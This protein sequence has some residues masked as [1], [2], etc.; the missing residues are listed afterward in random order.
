MRCHNFSGIFFSL[1]MGILLACFSADG[2]V[3]LVENGQER[4]VVITATPPSKIAAYAATELIAHVEKATGVR[5]QVIGEDEL[6]DESLC[7]IFIGVTKEAKSLGYAPDSLTPDTFILRTNGPRLY[8]FGREEP[9]AD[10]LRANVPSGTLF[11]VYELLERYVGVRW[12]WPGDLGTV[13]PRH[14]TLAI[15]GGLNE[16]QTPRL[17][18]RQ[19]RWHHVNHA[20]ADY[21]PEIERI[22]FSKEGLIAYRND[23]EI[24]LKRNRIGATEPKPKTGHYFCGWWPKYGKEHPEWFMLNEEGVRGPGSK[25][26]VERWRLQHVG[27]CV[28]NPELQQFLVE[29]AWDGSEDLD[30]SETDYRAFCH[31]EHCRSWD[32]E[33]PEGYYPD[34]HRMGWD[35]AL[36]GLSEYDDFIPMNVSD[37]YARFWKL[38]HEKAKERNPNVSVNTYLYWNYF[39]APLQEINLDGVYGEFVP[40]TRANKWMPMPEEAYEWNKEQWLGWQKTGMRMA[41]R[42]NYFHGGYVMPQISTRQA[43][44]FIRFAYKHGM[45]GVDFDS[46][47]GHWAIKAPMFYIHFRLF[48]NPELEVNQL[49]QE[50]FDAFGPSAPL[51]E[52]YTEY[53]EHHAGEACVPLDPWP[54][55]GLWSPVRAHIHYPAESFIPAAALL[56]EAHELA[57]QSNQMEYANRIAFL[58]HGLEHARL[59]G[60]LMAKLVHGRAPVFDPQRFAEAQQALKDLI[61][62]RRAFEHE[63]IADYLYAAIRENEYCEIDVLLR[64]AES[65]LLPNLNDRWGTWRFRKDTDNRG[66]D[67]KWYLTTPQE[68]EWA[69]V[70]TPGTWED[71]YQGY[72]WYHNTVNLPKDWKD[73]PLTLLFEGVSEEAW[74]YVNGQFVGEHTVSAKKLP[75]AILRTWPFE[76]SVPEKLLEPGAENSVVVRV[77]ASHHP[78]GF[79]GPVYGFVRDRAKTKTA[80]KPWG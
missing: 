32:V 2:T 10:P 72:A 48:W 6:A 58:Q 38:M 45:V 71:G 11:G 57:L 3:T 35:G 77:H 34:L 23:L 76:L 50:Y 65:A 60:Q 33:P 25:A 9:D 47:L 31:C 78:G 36:E 30:L 42:P 21:K 4:A 70:E 27:M 66:T 40:W 7:R 24:F 62:Y 69:A 39:P 51:I 29:D 12:M 68:D 18:F 20:V 17:C 37:R 41:Y 63:Y 53:W 14:E 44:E 19:I 46:L 1:S 79:S 67:E 49:R 55:S 80:E 56:E 5:L 22:S 26:L 16:K 54:E 61:A 52:Q 59:A 15:E 8:V 64:N 43:G 28:S 13:V 73:K 74:V 75:P